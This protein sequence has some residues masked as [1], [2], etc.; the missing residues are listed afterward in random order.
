MRPVTRRLVLA[1]LVLV[2]LL[3]ALGTLPQYLKAGDPYYLQAEPVDGGAAGSGNATADANATGEAVPAAN[4]SER[5]HPYT[6]E[7]LRDADG[8][9]TGRSS[10]YW[11]GPFG[12][13]EAFTHSPFDEVDSYRQ[14]YP[15]ATDGD[16]VRVR[17]GNRTYRL[18]VIQP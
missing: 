10:P 9:A 17:Y 7:A 5:A 3:L 14:Q 4:L 2:G 11:R 16:A 12:L 6:F 1:L 8:D 18:T 13:K 15:E